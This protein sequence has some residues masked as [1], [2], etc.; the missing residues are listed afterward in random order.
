MKGLSLNKIRQIES[1]LKKRFDSVFA[2]I[3]GY[4]K[5]QKEI[6]FSLGGNNL[7]SL[8]LKALG[9]NRNLSQLEKRTLK[10][11]LKVSGI[12]LDSLKDKSIAQIIEQIEQY[13]KYSDQSNTPPSISKIKE[14]LN[15]NMSKSL[16]YLK[17]VASAESNKA[18]NMGTALQIMRIAKE[19]EIK[20]PTVFFIVTKDDRTGF[21]EFILHLLPDRK[22]PRLWK[23]SELNQG[24]FKRGDRFPSICGL[25]PHC[26]CKLTYLAPGYS[27]DKKGNVKFKSL[28]WDELSN[29]RKTNPLPEVPKRPKK[30]NGKWVFD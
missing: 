29:Q 22:T 13:I 2:Q 17:E 21:Y 18:I 8:F 24:Y 30:S 15:D 23:L 9:K 26:R 3:L 7:I 4:Q 11:L 1:L 5:K 27:F 19:K 25:H 12:Y 20:D 28:D 10:V 6:S 14:I 16:D